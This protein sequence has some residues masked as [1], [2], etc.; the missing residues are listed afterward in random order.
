MLAGDVPDAPGTSS[1]RSS[2]S[3]PSTRPPGSW[4]SSHARPAPG[5]AVAP[6]RRLSTHI[7]DCRAAPAPWRPSRR[8]DRRGRL[9][10]AAP[11]ARR[12][13][14]RCAVEDGTRRPAT[15][16]GDPLSVHKERA[17]P[18]TRAWASTSSGPRR[19]AAG[20]G[21]RAEHR[22]QHATADPSSCPGLAESLEELIDPATRGDPESP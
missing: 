9:H 7:R 13:H 21:D 1:G 4:W 8:P 17:C 12:A 14:G 10:A 16:Q 20:P 22:G 6:T 3:N 18:L 2:A 15:S 11:A 5:A 19:R